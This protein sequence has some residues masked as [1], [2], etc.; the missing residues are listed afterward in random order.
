MNDPVSRELE[1]RAH[2]DLPWRSAIA[3]A[4]ALHV[5]F[6]VALLAPAPHR[7]RALT[8]PSVQ[9]RIV[10]APAT[11]GTARAARPPAPPATHPTTPR[12]PK[13]VPEKAPQA[14]ARHAVERAAAARQAKVPTPAAPPAA[15]AA[16]PAGAE[17]GPGRPGA[18]AA[19]SGGIGLGTPA[20]GDEPFPFS[21]YLNR[22]LAL[23]EGNWFRPPAPAGTTCQVRCVIDRSGRLA[24]A[25]LESSSPSP[26]F[27][28][29]ALR[30]VYAAAPFPPLPEGFGG[31]ELTLHLEFG[32]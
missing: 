27:D 28:R 18:V 17:P 10:A 32:P 4:L 31:N 2:L 30:A 14:P 26:A 6:A 29:A 1:Q 8:L 21:Y 23:V 19:P 5:A 16:G 15:T 11:A 12:R 20:A 7:A 24:E 22:V 3:G 25:G 9:V 13:A